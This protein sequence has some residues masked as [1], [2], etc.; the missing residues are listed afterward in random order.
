MKFKLPI[1]TSQM[2]LMHEAGLTVCQIKDGYDRVSTHVLNNRGLLSKS[3]FLKKLRRGFDTLHI[4]SY[5]F[6]QDRKL[7]S[8]KNNY[9]NCSYYS[10]DSLHYDDN[11]RITYLE[12][13]VIQK[14]GKNYDTTIHHRCFSTI[15]GDSLILL[16]DEFSSDLFVLNFNNEHISTVGRNRMVTVTL[17]SVNWCKQ[18]I[19]SIEQ[20][21]FIGRERVYNGSKLVIDK[22]YEQGSDKLVYSLLYS[23]KE[24]QL[25]QIVKKGLRDDLLAS[26]FF[27][28][29]K[30]GL[31]Q[32]EIEHIYDSTHVNSYRYW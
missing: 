15:D 17:D 31:I 6:D 7:I 11:N 2:R 9:K 26:Y 24:N 27:V 4:V 8:R 3:Y 10:F 1:D 29:N 14:Y 22:H 5:E 30:H 12:K 13:L 18:T 19:H 23:Y 28:Y 20:Q 21:E 25:Y 16:Q 32:Q